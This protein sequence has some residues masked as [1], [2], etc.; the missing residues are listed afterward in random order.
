DDLGGIC[1]EGQHLCFALA[2]WNG[3]DPIL[4]ERAFGLTGNQGNRG[5]D[6]KEYYG[7][8]HQT[9]LADA[10]RRGTDTLRVAA[11]GA[12]NPMRIIA[13]GPPDAHAGPVRVPSPGQSSRHRAQYRVYPAS[14]L[15]RT[16]TL[17]NG[18]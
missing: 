10:I 12:W 18:R 13:A 1:D 7:A 8:A 4:K 16:A 2:L 14:A 15:T 9:R 11:R 5:E 3:C 6:V 17:S